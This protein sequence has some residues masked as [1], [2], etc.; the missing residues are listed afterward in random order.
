[1]EHA[2]MLMPDMAK[3]DTIVFELV[4]SLDP[5]RSGEVYARTDLI[6]ELRYCALV[7]F[8][9]KALHSMSKIFLIV[10]EDL[11]VKEVS[12]FMVDVIFTFFCEFNIMLELADSLLYD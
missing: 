3:I 10:N 6:L 4:G 8:P 11:S 12:E 5:I 7:T 9:K 1:M 2:E